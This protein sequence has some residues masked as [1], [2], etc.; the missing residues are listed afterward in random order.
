M[1]KLAVSACLLGKRCRYDG[2]A[3]LDQATCD[4]AQ[5]EGA[6]AI[7][8]ECLAGFKIPHLPSEIVGGDGEDVLKGRAKVLDKA[9][10]DVTAVFIKGAEAALAVCQEAG[11]REAILKSRSP[12]CGVGVIYDGSFSGQCRPGLGVTA[13]LFRQ[14][15]ITLS[16]E[17]EA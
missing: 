2:S 1:T 6:V 9:G 11:V 4:R 7:C 10:M 3:K 17:E 14:H 5:A 12:S 8:P 15:G 16:T 13:A